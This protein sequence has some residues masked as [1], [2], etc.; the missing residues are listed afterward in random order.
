MTQTQTYFTLGLRL[1]NVPA[2]FTKG[3][4]LGLKPEQP[5]FVRPPVLLEYVR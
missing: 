4:G 1:Y 5:E 3:G 2:D